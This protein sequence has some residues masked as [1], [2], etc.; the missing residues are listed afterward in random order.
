MRT[1]DHQIALWTVFELMIADD[2]ELRPTTVNRD[3]N[4]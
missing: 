4:S 2:F 1:G 3:L